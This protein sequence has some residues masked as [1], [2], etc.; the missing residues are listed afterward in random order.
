MIQG[1][2]FLKDKN[3]MVITWKIFNV[4]KIFGRGSLCKL[5]KFVVQH[6]LL[7]FLGFLMNFAIAT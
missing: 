2:F 7:S 5:G 4:Q 1:L 6:F 3:K